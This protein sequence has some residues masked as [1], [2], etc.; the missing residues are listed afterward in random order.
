MKLLVPGREGQVPL[1]GDQQRDLITLVSPDAQVIVIKGH[2]RIRTHRR[3]GWCV[4]TNTMSGVRWEVR[5][6][7]GVTCDAGPV[8]RDTALEL[9][10]A[11]GDPASTHPEAMRA[12]GT[13]LAAVPDTHG[14]PPGHAVAAFALPKLT[15]LRHTE[16]G[17]D[18]CFRFADGPVVMT[19]DGRCRV[20]G[21]AEPYPGCWPG[22]AVFSAHQGDLT[23]LWPYLADA[24][25]DMTGA[26]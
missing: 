6:I 13:L 21:F 8:P 5:T 15:A 1:T 14:G 24:D 26:L 20:A 7:T 17:P 19:V 4:T 23:A 22:E 16:L 18:G 9:I 10:A 25:T 3:Y 2:M 12:C 11:W